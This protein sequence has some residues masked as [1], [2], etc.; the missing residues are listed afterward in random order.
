MPGAMKGMPDESLT[1]DTLELWPG[2][3]R[4]EADDSEGHSSGV[5]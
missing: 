3:Q 1:R 4:T 2:Q 5:D